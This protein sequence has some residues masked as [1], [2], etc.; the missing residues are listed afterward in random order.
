MDSFSVLA[1]TR[2]EGR[3]AM[4]EIEIG[5]VTHYFGHI[6]VAAI[7]LTK[8]ELSVGDTIRVKGHTSDFTCAVDSMQVDHVSVT[9]ANK[10]DGVGLRVPAKA[11][12][13]DKVYKVTP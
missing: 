5:V 6:D 7:Q 12:E 2:N 1:F 9:Q 3:R 4:P 10:G 11:H 13:H 8:G